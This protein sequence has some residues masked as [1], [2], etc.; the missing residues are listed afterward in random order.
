MW[1]D[2]AAVVRD[3]RQLGDR[4]DRPDLV[5]GVH[6]R[7]ERGVGPGVAVPQGVG[8]DDAAPSDRQERRGCQPRFAS[9]LTV[10]Q[11]GLVLDR[12]RDQMSAAGRLER[13]GG[14]AQR[15]VVGLGAAAREDDLGRLGA[16]ERRDRRSGVIERRLGPLAEGVD[17]D[18]LPNCVG[19]ARDDGLDHL[20]ASGC[21][22][23]VVEVDPHVARR[24]G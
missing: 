18:G 3:R 15:E 24:V 7:D 8:I 14:A 22:R 21:R 11:D 12:G 20:G 9:A 23:V 6:D 17:A 4:L 5:V 10:L 13:F 1:N 19:R 2:R 16:D